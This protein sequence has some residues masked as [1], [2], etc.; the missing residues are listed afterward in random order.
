[1]EN[2]RLKRQ[3]LKR[4]ARNPLNQ[5]S[6]DKLLS[7]QTPQETETVSLNERSDVMKKVHFIL[8]KKGGV[9]KSVAALM[10][11][12]YLRSVNE[13]VEVIDTDPSNA[14]LF[15]YK[16]LNGQ[17]IQL[18]EGNV[19]NEAKFDLM[20]NRVLEEDSSFVIDCGASSFIPLSNYMI[21][22]K[23]ADM[24]ADSG[25]QVVAHTV[26]V[27]ESNL[28]DTLT[29]FAELAEQMPEEVQIIVWLNEFFGKIELDGTPF[30]EMGFYL[31]NQ[32]RVHGIVRLPKRNPATF[33]ADIEKM[34]TAR[35]TFD[36]VRQS[37]DFFVMNK[38]RIFRVQQEIYHQLKD[39][40]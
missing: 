25:K 40:L 30:E 1:M 9:G 38:S 5:E 13:P 19:L 8:Q 32:S 20:M 23:V 37:P 2:R 34:L 12:Q 21:E 17:R 28:L 31:D 6:Q 18:M 24:I 11:A 3:V 14:T 22:N 27:G 16:A 29:S 26:I 33:G 39:V 4:E 15:S 36:E 10:L 35:L 7:A